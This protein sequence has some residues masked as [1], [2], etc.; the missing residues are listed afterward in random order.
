MGQVTHSYK[1]T[2]K[3]YNLGFSARHG[4]IKYFEPNNSKHFHG[5]KEL[6]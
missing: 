3:I 6:M 5:D 4:K 1:T 2:G